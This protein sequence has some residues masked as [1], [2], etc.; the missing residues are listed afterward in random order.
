MTPGHTVLSQ[1]VNTVG[2][3]IS[4]PG[5]SGRRGEVTQPSLHLLADYCTYYIALYTILR[6][7]GVCLTEKRNSIL[8]SQASTSREGVVSAEIARSCV[9]CRENFDTVYASD[10]EEWVSIG[11]VEH[12][13]GKG[14]RKTFVHK[15]CLSDRN[16]GNLSSRNS[17][18]KEWK[19]V[20]GR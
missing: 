5:S 17:L 15:T 1:K 12:G 18:W 3:L 2:C 11:A 14:G 9:L 8:G 20:S 7:R 13:S 19:D 4:R 6:H 16:N 10:A